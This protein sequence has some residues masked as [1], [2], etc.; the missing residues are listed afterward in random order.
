MFEGRPR[1]ALAMRQAGKARFGSSHPNVSLNKTVTREM[2]RPHRLD[3]VR[4]AAERKHKT[5]YKKDVV[6]VLVST[7]VISPC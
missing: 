7:A 6:V 5:D 2:R 4:D 1:F 3:V